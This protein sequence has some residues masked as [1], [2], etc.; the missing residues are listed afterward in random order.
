MNAAARLLNQGALSRGWVISIFVT[1]SNVSVVVFMISI[2]ISALSLV[3][4]TNC[5]RSLN[6]ELQQAYVERDHLRGVSVLAHHDGV[7]HLLTGHDVTV[8]LNSIGRELGR[9]DSPY[10]LFICRN[11]RMRLNR[12]VL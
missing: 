2:L 9:R 4:V 8:T 3:Y 5:S 10:A 12:S 7:L 11:R 6:A 1:R